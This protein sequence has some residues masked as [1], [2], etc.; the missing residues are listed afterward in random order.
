M[1]T[2]KRVQMKQ[3]NAMTEILASLERI[4]TA[5]GLRLKPAEA[6]GA[7]KSPTGDATPELPKAKAATPGAAPATRK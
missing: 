3:A 2:A 4:E 1:A 7:S 6:E 5:L